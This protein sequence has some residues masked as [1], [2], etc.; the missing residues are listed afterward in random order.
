METSNIISI[1][2]AIKDARKSNKI[3]QKEFARELGITSAYLC[4]IE[5]GKLSNF[6]VDILIKICEKL[7]VKLI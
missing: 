2:K 1:G 6:S 4:K 7:N 3:E 5:N